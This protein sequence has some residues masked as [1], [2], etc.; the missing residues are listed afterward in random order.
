MTGKTFTAVLLIAN[1]RFVAFGYDFEGKWSKVLLP[2]AI[3]YSPT[4]TVYVADNHSIKRFTSTGVLLGNWGRFGSGD[5][6]F[7]YPNGVALGPNGYVYVMD[8]GNNRVQ[9]FTSNGSFLGKWGRRG[10]GKLE[11][12]FP[13]DLSVSPTGTVYVAD[14]GTSVGFLTCRVQYFTSV[15]SF[16][17]EWG[18]PGQGVGEFYFPT[19][20]CCDRSGKVYVVDSGNYRVQYFTRDGEFLGKWGKRGW[21]NGEFIGAYKIAAGPH[22]RIF[23]S[24]FD[25][26][27]IQYFSPTGSF[28]GKFGSY[29]TGNGL[30]DGPAGV[31]VSITGARIYVCDNRNNRIQYFNRNSPAV[32]PTSLGKIRTLFE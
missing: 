32:N 18:R 13:N 7:S 11:F 19:G 15:G 31:T 28:V 23:V 12:E 4:G 25:R 21:G 3:A 8:T 17:G 22:Y 24:D 10:P 2:S 20:I 1:L 16:L 26:H 14:T 27:S 6:E 29:G 30:F 5:G 9:Y